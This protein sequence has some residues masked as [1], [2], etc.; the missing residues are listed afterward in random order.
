MEFAKYPPTGKRGVGLNRAQKYGFGFED[1]M[2][3]VRDDLI[4]VAQI[5]H[6][7]GINN[8]EQIVSVDGIDALIIGP[9][10][11]SGS[12]GTPGDFSNLKMTEALSKFKAVCERE[13]RCMG[14]HVIK[15]DYRDL[16][17]KKGQGFNF[18]AFSTDFYF[19]G[20]K[21]IEQMKSFKNE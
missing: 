1:Y 13:N 10:D 6:I 19:L 8:L 11:L 3:W 7:D 5:E 18:L 2:D 14:Y 15:P 12:L 9:Y 16:L 17:D 4:I 20:Y 21:A